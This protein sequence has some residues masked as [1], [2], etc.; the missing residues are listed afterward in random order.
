MLF[1]Y[2]SEKMKF[3]PVKRGRYVDA[4]VFLV[5]AISVLL[6]GL[7]NSKSREKLE[8]ITYE[9]RVL[10]IK[11]YNTFS[12]DRLVAEIKKLNFRF[13]H[14][15]LAQAKLESSN[16][17]SKLFRE[18]NNL[19]GMKEAKSRMTT[20]LGTERSYAYYETWKESL[21]DYALYSATYLKNLKTEGEYYRYLEQNYAEDPNYIQ[22]VQTTVNS[23]NLK[24]L[25]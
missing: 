10:I 11:E 24:S 7:S 20:A 13:P 15:V 12:E 25:F 23:N 17:T 14:I 19:F 5:S 21:F 8:D 22:K 3:E 6:L 1:K 4:R 9:E 16:F 18:N 2:S